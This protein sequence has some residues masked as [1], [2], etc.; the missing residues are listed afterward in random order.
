MSRNCEEPA[1]LGPTLITHNLMIPVFDVIPNLF[2]NR[3]RQT[4][5]P[6]LG[7]HLPLRRE[8]TPL[9]SRRKRKCAYNAVRLGPMLIIHRLMMPILQLITDL[10]VPEPAAE[11]RPHLSFRR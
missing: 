5:K 9:S 8:T 3:K 2:W 4:N 6:S 1:Y 10:S 7:Q 11:C